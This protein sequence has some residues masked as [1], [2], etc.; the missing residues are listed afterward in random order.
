MKRL[1]TLLL[2]LGILGSACIL[3]SCTKK[4]KTVAG[5]VLGAGAGVGIGAAVGNTGGAVAGGL[6]G[7]ATGGIIGNSLGDDK[8]SE[9]K[10]NKNHKK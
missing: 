3:S 6:I 4:E 8:K 7:A 10:K 2:I 9:P 1:A 5:A